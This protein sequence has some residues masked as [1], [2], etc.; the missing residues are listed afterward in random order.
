MRSLSSNDKKERL[1]KYEKEKFLD[2]RP[3]TKKFAH[4]VLVKIYFFVA[5]N[6]FELLVFRLLRLFRVPYSVSLQ[7]TSNPEK[8]I[9]KYNTKIKNF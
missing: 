4:F 3:S 2:P 1:Q 5:N 7:F 8:Y 6:E 9:C